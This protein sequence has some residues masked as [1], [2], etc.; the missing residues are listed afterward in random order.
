MPFHDR[1][2]TYLYTAYYLRRPKAGGPDAELR[3]PGTCGRLV[4]QNLCIIT[5]PCGLA[6]NALV[7]P[8]AE[9]ITETSAKL[10]VENDTY[11]SFNVIRHDP[12]GSEVIYGGAEIYNFVIPKERQL[13]SDDEMMYM[14]IVA[15]VI[16]AAFVVITVVAKGRA[17]AKLYATYKKYNRKD[18]NYMMKR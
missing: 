9:R 18:Y 5:T 17:K 12:D 6:R 3:A 1:Q 16:L 4:P 13:Q 10:N 8:D 2:H 14:G 11:Y 15:G 7:I